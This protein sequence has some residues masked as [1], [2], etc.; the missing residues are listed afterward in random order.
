[1]VVTEILEEPQRFWMHSAL[2][3]TAGAVGAEF[4]RA[5]LVQD[6]FGDDRTRRVAGAEKEH[7]VWRV[8]HGAAHTAGQPHDAAGSAAFG[9]GAQ[10]DFSC[11]TRAMRSPLPS[12]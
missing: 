2:G 3:L 11:A 7:V 8:G 9:T 1:R 5:H 6:R 12:P 10:H 4:P